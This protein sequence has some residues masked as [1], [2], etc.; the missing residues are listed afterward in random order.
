MNRLSTARSDTARHIL[1]EVLHRDSNNQANVQYDHL[2]GTKTTKKSLLRDTSRKTF[3]FSLRMAN[4]RV[5]DSRWHCVADVTLSLSFQIQNSSN[6]WSKLLNFDTILMEDVDTQSG[7]R[8]SRT[9]EKGMERSAQS[10]LVRQA[11]PL[12]IT[13]SENFSCMRSTKW[14]KPPSIFCARRQKLLADKADGRSGYRLVVENLNSYETTTA[15][16]AS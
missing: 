11:V 13:S 10:H 16:H 4:S 9:S 5:S 2:H 12:L 6:H 3:F 1:F 7:T 8:S 15:L 14:M